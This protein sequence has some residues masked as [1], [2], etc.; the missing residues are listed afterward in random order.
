M[1]RSMCHCGRVVDGRSTG[2]PGRSTRFIPAPTEKAYLGKIVSMSATAITF[3]SQS[4]T[5]RAKFRPMRSHGSSSRIRRRPTAAEG[6]VKANMRRPSTP[7]EG[8][9][10]GPAAGGGRG[11][12]FLPR[13]CTAQL[14]LSGAASPAE[15]G[16]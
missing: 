16:S 2:L 5:R 11:D 14:A 4:M 6:H 15:A 12:N 3:E 9:G 8:I 1:K 10:G 13:Y 7:E